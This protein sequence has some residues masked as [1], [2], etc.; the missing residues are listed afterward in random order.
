MNKRK[1]KTDFGDKNKDA[2]DEIKNDIGI[3][4]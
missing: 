4:K 3:R 1:K 2:N